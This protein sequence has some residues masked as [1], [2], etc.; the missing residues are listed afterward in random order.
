MVLPLPARGERRGNEVTITVWSCRRCSTFFTGAVS[1]LEP[2]AELQRRLA[3]P[4]KTERLTTHHCGGGGY[5]V[6]D[7][8]GAVPQ[9]EAK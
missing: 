4:A 2:E 6:A 5:G 3:Q 7:L 8:V 9:P 1:T